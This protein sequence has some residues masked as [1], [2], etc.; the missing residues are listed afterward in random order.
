[1]LLPLN[2]RVRTEFGMGTVIAS[3]ARRVVVGLDEGGSINVV[4]GTPGYARIVV[5]EA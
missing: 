5:E 4:T 2:A 3:S 1:M